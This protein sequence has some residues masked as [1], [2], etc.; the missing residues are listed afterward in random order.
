MLVRDGVAAVVGHDAAGLK[1]GASTLAQL[2]EIPRVVRKD[3]D[4]ALP[5]F[6]LPALVVDDGPD[7]L[8][9][10]ACLDCRGAAARGDA[11]IDDDARRLASWRCNAL[12]ILADDA[13]C[14]QLDREATAPARGGG[15]TR[16][17]S[18]GLVLSGASS[19]T[20]GSRR[21]TL[22]YRGTRATAVMGGRL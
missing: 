13:G 6:R 5:A 8:V 20:G 19:C 17:C 15:G 12:F 22:P 7:A 1:H 9:R 3:E 4:D 10:A 21:R 18:E 14:D 2:P 11:Q 16:T